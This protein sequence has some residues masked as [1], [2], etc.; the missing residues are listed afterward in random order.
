MFLQFHFVISVKKFVILDKFR[1]C[2]FSL[3]R[4]ISALL[5]IHVGFFETNAYNTYNNICIN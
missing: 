3:S 2:P 1:Y 5:Q 4:V